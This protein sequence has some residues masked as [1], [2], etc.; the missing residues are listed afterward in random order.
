MET[1]VQAYVCYRIEYHVVWIPKYRYKVL[2]KG[3]REYAVSKV[4]GDVKRESS[5]LL[6]EKFEYLRRGRDGLWSIG[7]F[8]S[9]VGL[10][11]SRIRRYVED[12]E[13]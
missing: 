10:D 5:R 2:V 12:Q 11:E 3:G 7:Y 8:V 6:R 9:I 1:R 13:E 4:I